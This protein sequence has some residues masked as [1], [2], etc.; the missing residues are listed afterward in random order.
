MREIAQVYL[1]ALEASQQG[2]RTICTDEM[3]GIQANERKAH[4]LPL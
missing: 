1:S 3:T 4:D 2:E